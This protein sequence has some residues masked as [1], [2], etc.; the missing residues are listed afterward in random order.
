MTK[1]NRGVALAEMPRKA[2]EMAAPLVRLCDQL[3]VEHKI[4]K[5]YG[6]GHWRFQFA[7]D[8]GRKKTIFFSGTPSDGRR[9]RLNNLAQL[10]RGLKVMGVSLDAP[11]PKPV[12]MK[13]PAPALAPVIP[14]SDT[15]TAVTP[16][17]VK[18]RRDSVT[19]V[20][21]PSELAQDL[22]IAIAQAVVPMFASLRAKAARYDAIRQALRGADQ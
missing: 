1:N 14:K 16:A 6:K 3:G 20:T 19:D 17:P 9:A 22:A 4:L 7:H 8:G 18:P 11:P 12:M 13:G 5:P 21:P 15:V 10:K 2:K